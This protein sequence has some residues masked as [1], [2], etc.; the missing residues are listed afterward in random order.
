MEDG[1]RERILLKMYFL[2]SS[3]AYLCNLGAQ[4]AEVGGSQIKARPGPLSKILAK[5][6]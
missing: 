3:V 6:N 4:K 2:R 5:E 1:A